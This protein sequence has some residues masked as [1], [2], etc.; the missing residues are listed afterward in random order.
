[1]IKQFTIYKATN[2]YIA[3]TANEDHF[4]GKLLPKL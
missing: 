1:M 3:V 2:G 4:I